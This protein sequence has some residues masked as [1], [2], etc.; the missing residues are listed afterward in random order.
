MRRHLQ[1][2]GFSSDRQVTL[3]HKQ[4]WVCQM[5]RDDWKGPVF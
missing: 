1:T 2:A 3:P 5:K 4:S